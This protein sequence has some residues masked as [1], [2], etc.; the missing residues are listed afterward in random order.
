MF[1][2]PAVH[3][4]AEESPEEAV[5]EAARIPEIRPAEDNSLARMGRVFDAM[6]PG[7]LPDDIAKTFSGGENV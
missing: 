5:E 3:A 7:D 4:Q 2:L 1:S 6:H